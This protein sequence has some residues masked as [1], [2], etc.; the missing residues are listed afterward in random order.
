MANSLATPVAACLADLA[1]A[2]RARNV[3]VETLLRQPHMLHTF[4]AVDVTLLDLRDT[5]ALDAVGLTPADLFAVDRA[6]CQ[7]VG[8]AAWHLEFD[9]V[10]ADFAAGNGDVLAMFENRFDATS[11]RFVNSQH[12]DHDAYSRLTAH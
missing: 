3:D 12:L 2:A 8:Q 6:R 4:K 7:E 10:I 5:A 11:L 1:G 9:G